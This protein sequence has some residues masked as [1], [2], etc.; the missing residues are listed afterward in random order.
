MRTLAVNS[1][2]VLG[3]GAIAIAAGNALHSRLVFLRRWSIPSSIVAGFLLAAI[4]LALRAIDFELVV[5]S[6]IQNL[7]MVTFFTSIG[8]SLDIEALRRGGAPMLRL[9]AMFAAGA[10]AQN[11]TGVAVAR[12][13]GLDPLLGIAAS[14]MALAGG[15]AT[16]LAFG[17]SF[18]EA[19][20]RGAASVAMGSALAGILFA[21]VVSSAFGAFLIAR[22][23]PEPAERPA[24]A[25]QPSP[26]ANEPLMGAVLARVS[27]LFGVAMG[28]G[29]ALNLML[30]GRV[31]G[32]HF[33]LPGYIGAM[34]VAALL[35]ACSTRVPALALPAGW[36]QAA[37][38]VALAWFI[39][40][41]LWTLKYW[42]LRGLAGPVFLILLAQVP[43]TFA[44]SWLVWRTQGRDSDAALIAAGYCGFMFGTTANSMAA[45]EEL[46]ERFGD[47]PK[48]FLIVP[49]VGGFLSDFINALLI[50]LG[51]AYFAT[52]D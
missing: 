2:W 51:C 8:F 26:L 44:L 20:A 24:P 22:S 9:L 48:A 17:L 37:G 18:E 14:G 40:L 33:S 12:S 13:Q 39:P 23:S 15:P 34:I 52:T 29:H 41:A 35:R 47:S 43:V 11:V 6:T 42:E 1:L 10:I 21:G 38:S 3:S 19:G 4:T 49:L 5:D 31:A 45:L 7:A 28:L 46:R 36:G 30:T 16:S 32:I 25:S 27:V 50:A